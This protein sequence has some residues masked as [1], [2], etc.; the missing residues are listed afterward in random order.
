MG[1]YHGKWLPRDVAYDVPVS[2]AGLEAAGGA[3]G[4]GIVLP[5]GEGT[6]PVG[7]VA[8]IARY[9]AKESS[10]Q[11]GPCQLG[12]PGIAR[13]LSALAE[14]SG[15]MDALDTARRAASAVRGRGACSHPDGTSRFVFSAM[16]VFT[17]DMAAHVFRGGCGR[18]VL[19]ILPLDPEHD[20]ARLAVDWTRCR[21]HGLCSR[22]VPELVQLDS[23]GFPVFLDMPVPFWLEQNA[24]QAVQMCPALALRLEPADPPPAP[25]RCRPAG[26]GPYGACSWPDAR[27]LYP[28]RRRKANGMGSGR[29]GRMKAA[30]LHAVGDLRLADEPVPEPG[31]G[32]SLV[33]VTAVG[34]CGSDLHWWGEGGIGDATLTRPLV[35]GHE[36]AGVIEDGPRRGELVAIDPAIWCGTCRPCRDGYRNLCTRIQFAGHGSQDGAMREFMAWPEH[37][38]H[39]LPGNLTDADGAMLEPLGVAIHALDLGHVRLGAA[40]AVV[41]CGPIGLLL[42]QV[43]RAAG[44]GL[45]A[46]FDPLP[47]RRAAATRFG[48]AAALDPAG[49]RAPGDLRQ[50]AGEGVDVA[51]E[52]AGT[53]EAVQL[54]ML[55]TRAGGRVVLGGIPASDQ[56]TFEASAARRKGLTIAMARRMNEVYPRAIGL[57]AGGQV[58]LASLVTGRFG[59]AEA[60]DAMAAAAARTGLKVIVEPSA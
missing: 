23:Q 13:S 8:R 38:L 36:A 12:L 58:E 20:E 17:D 27:S 55:A 14:G 46:A 37:L 44:A 41:G 29:P 32:M 54:A 11:C 16:E 31:P 60:P 50:V 4:A 34:I 42:I 39:P 3:L 52:M 35:L 28:G 21:G 45:I 10:G 24:A 2:R 43:L 30:R 5:L 15:G 48:A 1:G 40:A 19:G 57:A 22:L 53:D 47:H 9:L 33:R 51:F 6:C 59:L 18:P 49:V 25:P 26:P 7:E 56:I